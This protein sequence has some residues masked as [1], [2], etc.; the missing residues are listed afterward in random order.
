MVWQMAAEAVRRN[1]D[2]RTDFSAGLED[3]VCALL[4]WWF[5][6]QF[7]NLNHSN[8]RARAIDLVDRSRSEAMQITTSNSREEF[9]E[10]L[11]KFLVNDLHHQYNRL[12]ILVLHTDKKLQWSPRHLPP[13]L[14]VE[15]LDTEDLI[16]RLTGIDDPWLQQLQALEQFLHLHLLPYLPHEYRVSV[17]PDTEEDF[18]R[19][20]AFVAAL[21]HLARTARPC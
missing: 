13:G 8:P 1:A 17:S 14:V 21:K 2:N 16:R 7:E 20:N 4:N 5:G 15:L 18:K 12:I 10:T 19:A 11:S 6:V 9:N 3:T